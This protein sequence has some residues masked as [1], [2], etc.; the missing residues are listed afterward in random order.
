[1]KRKKAHKGIRRKPLKR[2]QLGSRIGSS[3]R[4]QRSAQNVTKI[5][6]F[7][8]KEENLSIQFRE[9]FDFQ[10]MGSD[11]GSSPTLI[12]VNLNDPVLGGLSPAPT[13]GVAIVVSGLK[14]GSTNPTFTNHSYNNK[15]NL[16]DRLEDYFDEYRSCVVT[17]S[18]VTFNVRPKL[19]QVSGI[20][21]VNRVSVVPYQSLVTTGQAPAGPTVGPT[22]VLKITGANAT[23]DLY[24]WC[25][26]QQ[27]EGQLYNATDG[28]VPLTTLKSGIPGLRMSKLNVTPNSTR[29][30]IFK[31]KYTP[32][33]QY[34]FKDWKDKK[35]L[36][37]CINGSIPNPEQLK[38]YAYLGIGGR[39]NGKDPSQPGAT[40]TSSAF[41]AN[42]CIEVSV[43]YNLNFSERR[44]VPGNNEP[45]PVVHASD[46]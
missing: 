4:A 28:V 29:G 35:E 15:R 37:N 43:K 44:N 34:Q 11:A 21:F 36:L 23:G 19:N 41:L 22:E 45:V 3:A 6:T 24:I 20:G 26:R 16:S 42:C 31:M 10:N 40:P 12:R 13:Q 17:S 32:K 30:C 8:R 2:F 39:I 7:S 46:L 1:M 5:S 38:A 27:S 25:V 33:S 18:E 9:E 14:T